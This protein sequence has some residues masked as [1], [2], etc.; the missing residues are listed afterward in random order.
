VWS[1]QRIP[2]ANFGF[3][4]QSRYFLE[5]AP[6]LSSRGWVDTVPDSL[7]LRKSD[8]AGNRTRDLLIC[9]QELWPLDHRGRRKSCQQKRKLFKH[10]TWK[11]HSYS[12]RNRALKFWRHIFRQ[13]PTMILA[14]GWTTE[15]SVFESR[16]GQEFSLLLVIH[17]G[18]G[19]DTASYPIGTGG[20][21]GRG[22]KLTSYLL[23]LLPGSRKCGSIYPLP[24]TSSWRSA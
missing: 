22:V 24:H 11:V 3:L 10:V 1:A 12:F 13:I 21:N 17:T 18:S 9:S 19:A 23:Q 2:T 5:T 7:R 8:S 16:Y 14:T 20:K 15:G 6:Q 4:D